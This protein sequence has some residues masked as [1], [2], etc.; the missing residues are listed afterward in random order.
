MKPGH[1]ERGDFVTMTMQGDFGKPRPALVIQSNLF[2]EVYSSV[3]VLLV[4][5][6]VIDAPL[7]RITVEPD[8]FNG[9]QKPSQIMV[10]KAMT[11]KRER[12]REPFGVA[13][14]EVMLAVNRSLLVFLG[15]A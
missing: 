15:I 5:S 8:E 2:N 10:D 3:T 11:I 7:F 6:D 12:L 4:T 13:G 14:D 1:I 9:L